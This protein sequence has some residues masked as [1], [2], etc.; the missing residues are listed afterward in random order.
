LC[1]DNRALLLTPALEAKE[2][3]RARGI[4]SREVKKTGRQPGQAVQRFLGAISCQG[5]SC[6]FEDNKMLWE[7]I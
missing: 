7:R 1:E 6:R 2:L 4:L 3:K 5:L